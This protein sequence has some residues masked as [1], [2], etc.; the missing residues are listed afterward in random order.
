MPDY[1]KLRT[2]LLADGLN[3]GY[4]LSA[5]AAPNTYVSGTM[6]DEQAAG[7]LNS[8]TTGR[9]RK[10]A[11]VSSAEMLAVIDMADMPAL[12]TNPNNSQLSQ[13]R[14]D[15]AWFESVMNAPT[16][17]LL[18]DDDTDTQ[19]K[20]N[21]AR[22][23]PANTGTRTRLLALQTAPISRAMELGLGVV[24]PSDVELART[25]SGGW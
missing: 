12:A 9:T 11:D 7:L 24:S 5:G 3:L 25:K 6:T 14:R 17:R 20:A 1:A 4:K 10:R 18:N 23:F 22:M 16:V 21:F 8:L 15:L 13:E 2:E 19:I